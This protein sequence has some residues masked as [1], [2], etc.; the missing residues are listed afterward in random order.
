M[1]P[2]GFPA[3][4]ITNSSAALE[5]VAESWEDYAAEFDEAPLE[6]RII[7]G[8][9]AKAPFAAVPAVCGQGHLLS[10]VADP[11]NQAVVDLDHGFAWC[12]VS[13]KAAEDRAWMRYHFI[14]AM[15]YVALTYRHF[16]PIH[17]AC[18]ERDGRGML[19]CGDGVPAGLAVP[20][21]I[22]MGDITTTDRVTIAVAN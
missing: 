15:V 3:R 5:A 17:A 1:Y 21:Q 6:V 11:A 20:V 18:V 22:R 14:E 12:R 19:L 7:V 10:I 16:T 4:F 9:D 8:E 13:S 2:L